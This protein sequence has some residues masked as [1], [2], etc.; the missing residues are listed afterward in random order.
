VLLEEQPIGLSPQTTGEGTARV[1]SYSPSQVEVS[2]VSNKPGLLFLSDAYYPAWKATVNG[3]SAKIYRADYA[4]RAVEIP[5][6]R[7]HTVFTYSS[8]W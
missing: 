3:Q 5:S 1:V 7:T 6:G 2:V 4:F 8:L